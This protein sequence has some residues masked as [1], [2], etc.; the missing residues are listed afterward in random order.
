MYIY[1]HLNSLNNNYV[2]FIIWYQ[3]VKLNNKKKNPNPSRCRRRPSCFIDHMLLGL[4][5]DKSSFI[6]VVVPPRYSIVLIGTNPSQNLIVLNVNVHA[7]LKLTVT[8]Y[9]AWLLQFISLLF[10]YDL[11]GFINGSKSC[12]PVMITLL[13][14]ASPSPNPNHF[15]GLRQDQ[16]LLNAIVGC[17]SA[18]LV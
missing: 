16:L 8:N 7:P 18:T 6:T 5:A 15:L 14:V 4:M 10:G 3:R 17:L 1:I 11:L 12:L 2:S 9:P 13:D